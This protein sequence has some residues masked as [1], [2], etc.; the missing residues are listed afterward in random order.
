MYYAIDKQ[1][2]VFNTLLLLI[3]GL[4]IYLLSPSGNV[5]QAIGLFGKTKIIIICSLALLIS[6]SSST[7]YLLIVLNA[8]SNSVFFIAG[9]FLGAKLFRWEGW[10]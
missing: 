3:S 4:S 6:S 5:K 1:F 7:N 9:G 10:R 2:S 8:I